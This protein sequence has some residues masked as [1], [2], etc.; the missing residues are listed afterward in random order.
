MLNLL[1][2]YLRLEPSH[3]HD[4]GFLGKLASWACRQ[5]R[6]HGAIA[7]LRR[8]D[9]ADLDELGIGRVDFPDLA[10][11]YA[12]GAAPLMRPYR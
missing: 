4:E 10:M 2:T 1:L 12:S 7:M 8:L 6:Y 9:N 5:A 11:R 3:D